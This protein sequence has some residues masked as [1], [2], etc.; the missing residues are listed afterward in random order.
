MGQY[1]FDCYMLHFVGIQSLLH[2]LAYMSVDYQCI[3]LH[4]SIQ[5]GR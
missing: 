2:I 4:K 5:L 1:I 3:Q